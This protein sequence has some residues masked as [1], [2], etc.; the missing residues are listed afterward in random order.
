MAQLVTVQLKSKAAFTY[1]DGVA[2]RTKKIPPKEL[3][4][5]TQTGARLLKESAVEAKITNWRGKLLGHKGIEARK[6]GRNKYGIFIPYYGIHLDRMSPHIVALKKGRLI[7]KW[8][9]QKLPYSGKFMRVRAHPYIN[10]GYRRM[11]NYADR[12]V[13]RIANKIVRG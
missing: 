12:I 9:K 8:A 7:T 5:L 1:L 2:H 4:N 10:R 11:V 6:I 3:W 13:R